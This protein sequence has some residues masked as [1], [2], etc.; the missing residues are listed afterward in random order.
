LRYWRKRIAE[1]GVPAFVAVPVTTAAGHAQIEITS[2]GVTVR[3]REDLDLDRL[4]ALV[5]VVAGRGREC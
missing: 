4:A 3:V 2:G 1:G 5:E